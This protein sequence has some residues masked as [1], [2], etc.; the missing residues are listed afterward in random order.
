MNRKEEKEKELLDAYKL[1]KE[2]TE[3]RPLWIIPSGQRIHLTDDGRDAD[4]MPTKPVAS[5]SSAVTAGAAAVI[6][7]RS[8]AAGV[9]GDHK[10]EASAVASPPDDAPVGAAARPVA[11]DP[12]SSSS[13]WAWSWANASRSSRSRSRPR[14]HP[15]ARGRASTVRASR[16]SK[17]PPRAWRR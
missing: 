4:I 7:K 13:S 15:C 2:K 14:S 1:R 9:G 5:S 8:Q 12:A 11:G 17:T 6:A 3:K 10:F 16:R